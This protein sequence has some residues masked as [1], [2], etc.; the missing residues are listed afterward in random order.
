MCS[1]A[2][3]KHDTMT[4][5]SS[6]EQ[7]LSEALPCDLRL[8]AYH[9]STPPTL[10][11]AV[12]SPPPGQDEQATFCE[13]HFIGI[14][15]PQDTSH[16]NTEL[17]LLAIEILIFTTDDLTTV[18]VS[19]ADT[20][21]CLNEVNPRPSSSSLTRAVLE[22]VLDYLL[23]PR[24]LVDD[25]V[26]LSLFARSQ[27]QYLFP[28]SIE[29]PHK[30]VLDDRQ[31][32][33]WW[34][35]VLDSIWRPLDR[36][37]KSPD[38]H[39]I[40]AYVVVP[41][42]DRADTRAFF[43]PSFRQD[44]ASAPRWNNAYPITLLAPDASLPLRCSIPRLPDDPKTRFLDDLDGDY[45]GPEGQWRNVRSLDHFW[46][47]MSYRQECLA[48]RLVGFVWVVFSRS[49]RMTNEDDDAQTEVNSSFVSDAAGD[50]ALPTP[51]QSQ[52]QMSQEVMRPSTETNGHDIEAL[53]ES[54][55]P[56]SPVLEPSQP[57]SPTSV[58]NHREDLSP[59]LIGPSQDHVKAASVPVW[60]SSTKGQV[61][62]TTADYSSLIDFLLELDFAGKI[63]AASSTQQFIEQA[64]KYAAA[65]SSSDLHAGTESTSFG[66][67]V[68]G[69][70]KPESGFAQKQRQL[71]Q[72]VASPHINMLSGVRKKRK[73][74]PND[75]SEPGE[76]TGMDDGDA[77][78]LSSGLVKKK[79]KTI[80][81]PVEETET[82]PQ[83]DEEVTSP[84]QNGDGRNEVKGLDSML[85]RKKVKLARTQG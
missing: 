61:I 24:L 13:S 27:N 31:L 44:P 45:I 6:L 52:I 57:T 83:V 11:D 39:D 34:C 2:P 59:V 9:L 4:R 1:L 70:K 33:K 77:K 64:N 63:T 69:Q 85:V 17:F 19:K 16:A 10:S 54:P 53:P 32:I 15:S 58:H 51:A 66:I 65:Y 30:H 38:T 62:I 20:S 60:P 82:G 84:S 75:P 41:G 5:T 18:F 73:M 42:C 76:G 28:G 40:S 72:E 47:M 25:K 49:R 8:R 80:G 78:V 22:T 26:V 43:P 35:R 68:T 14:A 71:E 81:D 55:P 3:S 67:T 56:S 79:T 7:R 12:F 50:T 36:D 23:Q 29:N 21:G 74:E 48:G 46:E 37:L